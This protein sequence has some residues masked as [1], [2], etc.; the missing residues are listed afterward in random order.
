MSVD[1][2]ALVLS[3]YFKGFRYS[4]LISSFRPLQG[5]TEPR[6]QVAFRRLVQGSP[7]KNL[8]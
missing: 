6:L 7:G 8:F 2:V 1:C 4:R 5:F 3:Q